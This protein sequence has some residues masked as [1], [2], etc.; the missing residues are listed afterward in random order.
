MPAPLRAAWRLRFPKRMKRDV[1]FFFTAFAALFGVAVAAWPAFDAADRR[2][3]SV[4]AV[5]GASVAF[6]LF[7]FWRPVWHAFANRFFLRPL[8]RLPDPWVVDGDTI[9]DRA[10]GI[11]YRFANIDA[12][13]I[14]GAKCYREGV[15]GQ[16]AKWA[17]VRLVR[18]AKV[19][20]VRPTFRTDQYGRRVAFVLIDDQD[21]GDIL[22]ARGLAVPWGGW[23]KRWCGPRGGLAQIAKT[24][25][26]AHACKACRA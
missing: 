14:E 26:M 19:V 8:R 16:L 12:P 24:G 18:E 3:E 6:I 11:R 22:V 25:A 2:V 7:A 20:A 10:T 9:D 4:A 23:R 13:E 17:L 1:I 5:A 21:A 15:R